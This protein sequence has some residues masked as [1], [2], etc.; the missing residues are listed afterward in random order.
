M[1]ELMSLRRICTILTLTVAGGITVCGQTARDLVKGNL[2]QFNDNGGWRWYQDERAVIDV[3][4]GK[5][6]L[7]SDGSGTGVGGSPRSGDVEAVLF[8]LKT[9][10][11]QRFTLRKGDPSVFYCDDHCAP[12]FI[13]RPDGKYLTFYAAHFNDSSSH[14]RLYDG[15]TWG[16]G[17]GL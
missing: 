5:L 8:D 16:A 1:T 14:Y 13:V 17:K 2:I 6:L 10:S 9:R 11:L 4:A 12:A 3:A 7:G 15:S